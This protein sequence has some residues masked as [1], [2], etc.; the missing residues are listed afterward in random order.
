MNLTLYFLNRAASF[1]VVT[2]RG[3][4]RWAGYFDEIIYSYM[5]AKRQLLVRFRDDCH[6]R[7]SLYI[8]FFSPWRMMRH[9]KTAGICQPMFSLGLAASV[10]SC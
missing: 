7:S 1:V 10:S 8:N 4:I 6:A 5:K 3:D 9:H 2:F